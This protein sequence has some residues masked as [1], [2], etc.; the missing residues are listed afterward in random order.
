MKREEP[1]ESGSPTLIRSL[2][3]LEDDLEGEA[4]ATI[5]KEWKEQG[6]DPWA[7]NPSPQRRTKPQ[8][9]VYLQRSLF[10]SGF[11]LKEIPLEVIPLRG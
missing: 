9:V 4:L 7:R 6:F 1:G 8:R 10:L 3:A 11:P 2:S 5:G